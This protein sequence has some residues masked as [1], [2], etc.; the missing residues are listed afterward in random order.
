MFLFPLHVVNALTL[1]MVVLVLEKL[2]LGMARDRYHD[3]LFYFSAQLY[4]DQ[5]MSGGN[6]HD[7]LSLP[8][9][10]GCAANPP[11][12]FCFVGG[13]LI[14]SYHLFRAL[15]LVVQAM[16]CAQFSFRTSLIE[17]SPILS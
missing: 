5:L 2:T 8:A 11:V 14:A 7:R 6:L 4:A 10:C 1:V 16:K 15:F 12:S 13:P 3:R 9:D 17:Y